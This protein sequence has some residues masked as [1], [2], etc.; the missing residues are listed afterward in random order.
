M[1]PYPSFWSRISQ[2]LKQRIAAAAELRRQANDEIE[3]LREKVVS[4]A[5]QLAQAKDENLSLREKV[6]ALRL[7]LENRNSENENLK[8]FL[9]DAKNGTLFM[10]AADR[11]EILRCLHPDSARDPAEQRRLTKAFQI[12]NALPI[13]EILG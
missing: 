4:L 8:A 1:P 10:A 2:R 3:A 13:D 12:F 7:C 5:L 11:R 9:R 6:G